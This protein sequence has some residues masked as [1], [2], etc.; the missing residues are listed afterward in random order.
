MNIV[1]K[2]FQVIHVGADFMSEEYRKKLEHDGYEL[3]SMK[4]GVGRKI[5]SYTFKLKDDNETARHT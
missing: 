3:V 1:E 2:K 4:M 5:D